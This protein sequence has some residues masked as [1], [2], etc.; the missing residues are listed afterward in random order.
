M[1]RPARAITY[2]LLIVLLL[3]VTFV[4]PKQ[5][6]EAHAQGA[7]LTNPLL[8]GP[9]DPYVIY[10]NGYYYYTG[11]TATNIQIWRS[12]TIAGLAS[13]TPVTVWTPTAGTPDCC[14]LWAPEL[15]YINN[16][17]YIYYAADGGSDSSH[18]IFVL[19]A[20]SSDPLGSYSEANT[21][22]P[23]GQLS[24]SSNLWAIDP[25]VFQDSSGKLFAVWSGWPTASGG[26]QNI[27]IASMSDPLHISSNRVQI[28]AP[29]RSWETHGFGVNEGPVGFTHNGKTFITYSASF[30]GTPNYAVGLLTNNSTD[31]TTYLNASNW[32]KTGPILEQHDSVKGPASFVPIQS[33]DGTETWFLYHTTPGGC[34]GTRTVQAQKMYWDSDGSPLLGYPVDANVPLTSPSGENG[35]FG[36]SPSASGDP[37]VGAWSNNSTT[38]ADST[39][40]GSGWHQI[41]RGDPTLID[42]T[43]QVDAQGVATGTTSAYPKY[44][45]YA[46][47][48]DSNN[49]V[50]GW[51]DTKYNVFATY[52]V[53][54]GVAQSWQNANL[55][56]GF[57]PT[58]FHTIKVTKTDNVFTFYLDG[59]QMQQRSFNVRHG[60]IGL[61]TED[62][63]A[64]YNNVSV[65]DN[66]QGWRDAFGDSAEGD[67][68]DGLKT[69]NWSI[70]GPGSANGSSLG[71]GWQQIFRGNP[72]YENY[73]VQTDAQWV[74]TGTTSAYPKYGI[75]AAYIDH[76]N[77][78]VAFLDRQ[79]GVYATYAVVGGT[80]QGWQNA[81][82]P[83]GFNPALYHTI[84]VVK[85]GSTFTFYLDGTQMQQRTFNL[86]DG[87]PGLVTE[88]T[89][90]NYRNF[91]VSNV[92]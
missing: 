51:I 39:S 61:V 59:T 43:V 45:M 83:A 38:S 80:A 17:W 79:Y 23:H 78:V 58:Q 14:D 74:Q 27:Y 49:Y 85:A 34:D 21:G 36:W 44:G 82:L 47:Y 29:T 1:K 50:Q 60:Q 89:A 77:Y 75:Y 54:G 55:P 66:S 26:V 64:N 25:N 48:Q 56:V 63:T 35:A 92:N 42:Y 88:D 31:G 62:R 11:T 8:T 10:V 81:N 9:V 86:L 13:A 18:R 76:N 16:T 6:P 53:V 71:A 46:A 19:Q 37:V 20:N 57:D 87:Q 15:H 84:K 72:N 12:A 24:E 2:S 22:N 65:T 67:T 68:T 32:T 69:G 70:Q 7:T 41:F 33:E 30:C 52:A 91:S 3:V 40:L 73:T 28:S 4:L 90:A 5:A